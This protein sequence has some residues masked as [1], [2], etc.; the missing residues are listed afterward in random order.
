MFFSRACSRVRC[1]EY[2]SRTRS[3]TASWIPICSAM[4]GRASSASRVAVVSAM[5]RSVSTLSAGR[6]AH[7]MVGA[8]SRPCT[9]S[10]VATT[11]T[12]MKMMRSRSGNGE[13]D[14]R[15]SGME[16]ATARETVPRNSAMVDTTRALQRG[17]D[18]LPN[19]S[20]SGGRSAASHRVRDGRRVVTERNRGR[21]RRSTAGSGRPLRCAVTALRTRG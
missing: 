15:V 3:V 19:T 17:C 10:V 13:P 16:R 1:S 18:R 7:R 4:I 8:S 21:L 6:W 2:S 14:P 12:V 9:T 11:P 5:S 20:A